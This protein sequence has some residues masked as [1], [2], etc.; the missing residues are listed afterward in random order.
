MRPRRYYTSLS[1]EDPWEDS[2]WIPSTAEFLLPRDRLQRMLL[3]T[4]TS[5]ITS[6]AFATVGPDDTMERAIYRMRQH[7]VRAVL[8]MRGE[9]LLGIVT[10]RDAVM[11]V[12]P[13]DTGANLIV[14]DIMTPDPVIIG[15]EEPVGCA[16]QR[17]AVEGVHHL[18]VMD[19]FELKVIGIVEQRPLLN[20]II[21]TILNEEWAAEMDEEE[22]LG[23]G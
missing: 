22:E 3:E 5:A 8:V 21:E 10:E 13:G 9:D 23:G 16:V 19:A 2:D 15:E 20:R 17:L 1:E 12:E 7:H 4:P 6:D 14:R 18:P 11:H